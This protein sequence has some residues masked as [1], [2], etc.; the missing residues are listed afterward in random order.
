M[1]ALEI[2]SLVQAYLNQWGFLLTDY[3]KLYNIYG[4]LMQMDEDQ[5]DQLKLVRCCGGLAQ[6]RDLTDVFS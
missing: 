3:E 1:P 4:R 2:H 6:W 5:H